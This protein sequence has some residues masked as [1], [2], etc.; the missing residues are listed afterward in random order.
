I[1]FLINQV[2]KATDPVKLYEYF[3]LGKPVVATNMA[4]LAQCG[5]LV[6][7]GHDPEDFARKVDAAVTSD[8]GDL[9]A[10]RIDFAQA[11]TWSS[12]VAEI[13]RAIRQS[14]P[15]VS[16]LIVTYNSAAFVRPC[17]DSIRRNTSYPRYEVILVDNASKD[18]TP[19]LLMEYADRDDHLRL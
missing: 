12:P 10:R 1:P 5:D 18:D 11:N 8:N 6:H 13:D 16:I 3:S 7:I 2:T 9:R 14:F 15:L 4:E 19:A 17:L